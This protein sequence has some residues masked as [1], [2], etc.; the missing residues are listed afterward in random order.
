[1]VVVED[2]KP[3]STSGG[4]NAHR[5]HGIDKDG[6]VLG[7][8]KMATNCNEVLGFMIT[9]TTITG[10]SKTTDDAGTPNAMAMG[11]EPYADKLIMADNG[12]RN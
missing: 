10:N 7:N 2:C 4:D 3:N 9:G 11:R 6:D 12:A 5:E 8:M 1:M